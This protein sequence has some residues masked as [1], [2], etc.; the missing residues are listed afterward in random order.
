MTWTVWSAFVLV[1]TALC[2]TPGPRL[3][4]AAIRRS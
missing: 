3:G 4:M 2:L 1:E